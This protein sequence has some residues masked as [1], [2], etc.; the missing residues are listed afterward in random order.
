MPSLPGPKSTWAQVTRPFGRLFCCCLAAASLLNGADDRLSAGKT[1]L[2]AGK[3]EEA[4]RLLQQD[5]ADSARC[6]VSFY[7][8]LARYRLRQ[9]DQAIIALESAHR[10]NRDNADTLFAL[11]VAYSDK[12]DDDRAVAAFDSA[13]KLR[14]DNLEALRAAAA[15]DLRHERNERAI[16]K[17]KKIIALDPQDAQARSDLGAAFA[18]IGNLDSAREQ[19]LF[20]LKLRPDDASAL[21]GLGNAHLKAG[22]PEEA[23]PLLTKAAK[24]QPKSFE[25]HFLLASAFNAM[26]RYAEAA[27]ECNEAIRLGGTDPEVY[28]HLAKAYRG[29]G[30]KEDERK[31]LA[32]FSALRS[33]SAHEEETKREADRLIAQAKP[34]V[35]KGSLP[36]AIVLLE[37]AAALDRKNPQ[38]LFRLAGLYYDVQ[39][40]EAARQYV[41]EAIAITPSEWRYHYL[42]GLVEKASGNMPAAHESL[43]T[44]TRLNPS[45]ADPV[46][47]L[48]NLAMSRDD[49]TLAIQY[50]EKA[51]RLDP[52]ELAY[53]LNL[54]VA[55][56]RLAPK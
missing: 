27:A 11:A 56:R 40:Q 38:V 37:K 14:P 50:F 31:A 33:Q 43:E 24:A 32:Q 22:Q 1:A 41:R 26:S 45:A 8:G 7:L 5:Q 48:G 55:Q 53:R 51:T 39:R 4:V 3:F 42:L 15:I 29:L 28:Y 49:V 47:Q 30:R 17:L 54:D 44:A 12:G 18:A 25:P 35:D 21:V 2:A 36:D 16:E 13:I 9:L 34:L 23:I 46:N 52:G 19:F 10:C 20:A 6:E